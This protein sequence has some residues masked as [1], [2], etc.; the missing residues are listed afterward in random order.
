MPHNF[1]PQKG[2]SKM[3]VK[4]KRHETRKEIQSL[5]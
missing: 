4:T 5:R 2:C 1:A 3:M